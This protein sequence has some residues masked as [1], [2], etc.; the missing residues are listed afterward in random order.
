MLLEAPDFTERG[1]PPG[2]K[3][4]L[5]GVGVSSEEGGVG[6]PCTEPPNSRGG[7]PMAPQP[8]AM[9]CWPLALCHP[10]SP[11]SLLCRVYK[12]L[13]PVKVPSS[14]LPTS[15]FPSAVLFRG[16]RMTNCKL[17][18]NYSSSL[19]VFYSPPSPQPLEWCSLRLNERLISEPINP[20]TMQ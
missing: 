9:S 2:G 15:L 3:S 1:F 12:P 19:A 10:A 20:H 16:A 14:P 8:Q 6:S 7:R 4:R 17:Y 5:T 18:F 11:A 13:P